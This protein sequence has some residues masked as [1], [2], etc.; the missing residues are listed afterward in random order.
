MRRFESNALAVEALLVGDV[1]AV[2]CDDPTAA[3]YVGANPGAL[4]IDGPPFT[5]EQY[6]IL[7]RND[8]PEVLAAFDL[9]IAELRAD[10]TLDQLAERWLTAAEEAP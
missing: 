3:N 8:A 5:T 2:V 7:V 6:G 9:A 10:G 1:D 4:A